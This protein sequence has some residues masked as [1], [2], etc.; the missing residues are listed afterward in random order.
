MGTNAAEAL[1]SMIREASRPGSGLLATI[2]G[3]G[4][5]VFAATGVFTETQSALNAIWKAP[6]HEGSTYLQMLR[7]RLASIGL[8]VAL[9]FL[10]LVSLV[11]SAALAAVDKRL[12]RFFSGA[13]LVFQGV[14]ALIAL[15][16]VTLLVAAIYKVLPDKDVRWREVVAGAV[17]TS[18]LF[19]LGKFAIAFYIGK[20]H[21]ATTYGATGA[22]VIMLLWVYYTVQILLLGAEFT[23]VYAARH[24]ND[25]AVEALP[26][27]SGRATAG[28]PG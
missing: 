9:G 28:R 12:E 17:M 5:L 18:C 21:I 8:V 13:H 4:T 24:G 10:M 23:K 20:S 3:I 6:P 15:A 1:Q 7:A 19:T 22:L 25:G 11:V 26:A 27:R 14:S 16:L 2:I